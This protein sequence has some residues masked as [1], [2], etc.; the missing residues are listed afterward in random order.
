M[1]MDFYLTNK[2]VWNKSIEISQKD[3]VSKN[4][5]NPSHA[6]RMLYPNPKNAITGNHNWNY[7]FS[8]NQKDEDIITMGYQVV[9]EKKIDF[10][11][12]IFVNPKIFLYKKTVIPLTR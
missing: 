8:Y 9:E 7:I 3:G 11:L 5:I 1:L 10:P 4:Q 6:W 2:F 12:N